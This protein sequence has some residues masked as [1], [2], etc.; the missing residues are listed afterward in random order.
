MEKII[1]NG[2]IAFLFCINFLSGLFPLN[3]KPLKTRPRVNNEVPIS[4]QDAVTPT[5]A[6]LVTVTPSTYTEVITQSVVSPDNQLIA[7]VNEIWWH[8]LFAQTIVIRDERG[9]EIEVIPYKGTMPRG[10][11]HP[12]MRI[13][14]WSPDSSAIFFYYSWGYDGGVPTLFDGSNLQAFNIQNHSYEDIAPGGCIAYSVSSDGKKI[15]YTSGDRIGFYDISS[16]SSKS[17]LIKAEHFAQSGNIH[18]SRGD[19]AVV[20]TV[21]LD[22]TTENA[23]EIYLD[24][25]TMSQTVLLDNIFEESYGLKDWDQDNNPIYLKYDDNNKAEIVVIDKQSAILKVIGTPTPTPTHIPTPAK[26]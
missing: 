6:Q 24:E 13:I 25:K 14:G 21:M 3:Q 26:K 11:P 5:P 15:A 9:E 22:N 2:A 23:R 16:R 20:F 7:S 10:D 18:W 19:D 8:Y 4:A 12:S 1:I 17:V